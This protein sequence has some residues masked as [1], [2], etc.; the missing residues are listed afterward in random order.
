MRVFA[1]LAALLVVP[2]VLAAPKPSKVRAVSVPRSAVT[3]TPWKAVVSVQPPA[4][5]TLEARNGTVVRAALV[6]TKTRGRYTATLR[7]PRAG[8]WAI[9]REG[10]LADDTPRLGRRRRPPRPAAAE[11]VHDRR[12]AVGLARRRAAAGR[13]PRAAHGGRATT[14]ADGLRVFHVSVAGEHDLRGRR[15]T[16]PSTGSTGRPRRG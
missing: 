5:A 6:A 8:T 14:I 1:L 4:R 3:G 15:R 12:R 11:P 13:E 2:A 9:C 16:A 7:F 10:R